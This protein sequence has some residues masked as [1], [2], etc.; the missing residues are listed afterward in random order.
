MRMVTKAVMRKSIFR[1]GLEDILGLLG[2][3]HLEQSE[4]DTFTDWLKSPFAAGFFVV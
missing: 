4:R 1:H 2:N 3:P